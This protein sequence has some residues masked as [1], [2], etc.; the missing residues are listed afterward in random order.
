MEVPDWVTLVPVLIIVSGWVINSWLNRRHEIAKKRL[1]YRMKAL[2][3][4]LPFAYSAQ[5]VFNLGQDEPELV[6]KLWTVYVNIHIYGSEQEIKLIDDVYTAYRDKNVEKFQSSYSPLYD[7][8]RNSL[9]K[10]LKL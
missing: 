7:Y 5:K 3:S 1:E 9:R 8:L 4:F 2:E 6:E 10:E